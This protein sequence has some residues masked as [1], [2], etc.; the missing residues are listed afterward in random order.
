MLGAT[1]PLPAGT[2]KGLAAA[3]EAELDRRRRQQQQRQGTSDGSQPRRLAPQRKKRAPPVPG[4]A[5]ALLS[6][7]EALPIDLSGASEDD[8]DEI[9]GPLFAN[10]EGGARGADE[11]VKR[12]ADWTLREGGTPLHHQPTDED[13]PAEKESGKDEERE[14]HGEIESVAA[15]S[16]DAS[17]N[18]ASASDV[19]SS[20][21]DD[22]FR[23][24]NEA[25]LPLDPPPTTMP[26]VLV[27][28]AALCGCPPDDA[29]EKALVEDQVVEA[30]LGER[31]ASGDG[32]DSKGEGGGEANEASGQQE[33]EGDKSAKL[34][35]GISS[36]F[37]ERVAD[38]FD[39]GGARHVDSSHPLAV[40]LAAETP[41]GPL[42]EKVRS[43]A[44]VPYPEFVSN[45]SSSKARNTVRLWKLLHTTPTDDPHIAPLLERIFGHLRN[46]S[47]S[48]LWKADMHRELSLTARREYRWKGQRQKQR[49]YDEWKEARRGE[50]LEKLYEV[51]E[52]FQVRA[53]A[54]RKKYMALVEEREGRVERELQRRRLAGRRRE[55]R[56]ISVLDAGREDPT[57]AALGLGGEELDDDGWGGTVCEDDVIGEATSLDPRRFDGP[58]EEDGEENDEWSPLQATVDPLGMNLVLEGVKS[59]ETTGKP[60]SNKEKERVQS[61]ANRL[62]PISRDDN[63]KRKTE[64]RHKKQTSTNDAAKESDRLRA[65]EHAIRERLKTTEERMAHATLLQVEKRLKDADDLLERLQEEEWAE[66]EE[67]EEDGAFGRGTGDER[68]GGGDETDGQANLLDQILAM[69][70]GMLPKKEEKTTDEAHYRYIK[71]EHDG[72]VKEW[73]ATFGRLPPFPPAEPE[74]QPEPESEQAGDDD[75]EL[76]FGDGFLAPEA[77]PL[78]PLAD[79]RSREPGSKAEAPVPVGNDGNWDEVDDWDAL[80]P[81]V[82]S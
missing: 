47:R 74:S 30:L 75:D 73:M 22:G 25:E 42:Q 55:E 48:L 76:P 36:D 50:S 7:A 31:E 24:L 9:A 46:A 20:S 8:G 39:A 68:G 60:G 27:D 69:I 61:L 81:G 78:T 63:L 80:F 49:E 10:D 6:V 18:A 26:L 72:I 66:E 14:Y 64:R 1:V 67:D 35:D 44:A 57:E 28:L 77:T 2:A 56:P 29:A 37:D 54:A 38:L 45:S 70:L 3:R 13:E 23:I 53:D 4:G 40:A 52:T 82:V 33:G 21:E 12:V 19:S 62:E 65:E 71:E 58:H 17:Q 79:Q 16:S 5:E 41:N 11:M 59:N 43:Y 51:R 32:E 15:S 34:G